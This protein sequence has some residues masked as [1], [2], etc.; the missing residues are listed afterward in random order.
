MKPRLLVF[1][2]AYNAENTIEQVLTRIP[3]SLEEEFDIEILVIDDASRDRTFEK[4][5]LA[6]RANN[7]PFALHVLFNPVNQGYGG[8]QKIGF[9]YAIEQGFD[10]VAL[11]HGDGQYAPERLPE[12]MQPLKRGEADA[13]FGSRMM[14]QGAARAGGMPLY[15]YIGNKILTWMQNRLLRTHLSEFHSGYRVYSVAA[16][17]KLP[18]ELNTNVFH[19][20]T[21]IIIQLVIARLRIRE[22][23]IPT[24][25]GD[26]ICNVDGL[27]YAWDV[28]IATAKARMQELSLFYDRKYDCAPAITGN[29]QYTSKLDFESP[30]SIVA[31][32]AGAGSRVLDLGCAGGYLSTD[33]TNK[34]ASVVAV[35]MF[36]LA[37]GARVERFIQHDL[38]LPLPIDA[39]EFDYVLALDV[40]EHLNS[41]EGFVERLRVALSRNA[42]VKVIVSTGNVGFA[43]PRLML[44]LGQFNY[45]KRGILDIT[46]TRLFTTGSFRRLFA[47]AG[48]DVL[49]ARGIPA[50]FPLALGKGR[51]SRLLLN[52]N[53][54]MIRVSPSLFAFQF[55]LVVKP[56]PTLAALL[57]DAVDHSALRSARAGLDQR[58]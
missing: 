40:I 29:D 48:F 15:K 41:P 36:P 52:F 2:V 4:S 21:E 46:H 45:G 22:V 38:N 19:F 31:G 28:M 10:F 12:L 51:L 9:H 26:E 23:P 34:G 20:D 1:I 42:G 6:R 17:K 56:R 37:P 44:L 53:R 25:Y 32:M 43:I 58:A 54:L 18:F 49:E 30:H 27:R 55:L 13:V 50:P 11:V 57:Q 3:V 47:Q 39:S 14:T 24:Y 33:L 16:L 7:L 5:E 8:N 35:D